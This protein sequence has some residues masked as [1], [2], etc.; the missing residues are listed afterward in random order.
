MPFFDT[1]NQIVRSYGWFD[2]LIEIE[3]RYCEIAASGSEIPC[4]QEK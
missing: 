2:I 3:E 1:I 4:L